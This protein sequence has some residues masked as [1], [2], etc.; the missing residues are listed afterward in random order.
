MKMH[1]PPAPLSS[2]G[3]PSNAAFLKVEL[4]PTGKVRGVAQVP[5]KYAGS[6]TRMLG[7]VGLAVTILF[8]P[9]ATVKATNTHLSE[10]STDGI[11]TMQIVSLAYV[12]SRSTKGEKP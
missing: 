9:M 8:A 7:K 3:D 2:D 11:I 10:A 1:N 6:F 5:G 4:S 12:A